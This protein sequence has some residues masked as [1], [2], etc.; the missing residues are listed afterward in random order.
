M[1]VCYFHDGTPLCKEYEATYLGKKINKDVNIKHEI[2][3][4]MSEVRRT[5]FKLEPYWKASRAGKKWK[6]IIFDAI[7]RS[8]LMYG[9]ET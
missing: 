8:K 4:K 2:F 6:L 1:P 3:N 5:W 9:L 7:I